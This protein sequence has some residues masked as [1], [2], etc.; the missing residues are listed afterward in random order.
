MCA[1]VHSSTCAAGLVR[2]FTLKLE[3]ALKSTSPLNFAVIPRE[4]LSVMH[5]CYFFR[6]LCKFSQVCIMC[7]SVC[8]YECV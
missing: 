6:T 4:V 2:C 7:V 5:V 1:R 8:V 3:V